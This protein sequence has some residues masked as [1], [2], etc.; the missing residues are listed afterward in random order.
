MCISG[1][2]GIAHSL[3]AT[4][5]QWFLFFSLCMDFIN[6]RFRGKTKAIISITYALKN[7][8]IHTYK[9]CILHGMVLYGDLGDLQSLR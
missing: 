7:T 2:D 9:T 3:N 1:E 4:I 6:I 5:I 8:R